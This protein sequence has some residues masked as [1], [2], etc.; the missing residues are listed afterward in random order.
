MLIGRTSFGKVA[1]N[2]TKLTKTSE[3][4]GRWARLVR[5]SRK[6]RVIGRRVTT[7]RIGLIIMMWRRVGILSGQINKG[8][9]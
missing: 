5:T 7:I 2:T 1:F 3:R 9:S 4:F 8:W 6:V